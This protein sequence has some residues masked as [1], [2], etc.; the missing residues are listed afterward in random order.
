MVSDR[1]G[2]LN[3]IVAISLAWFIVSFTWL[4]VH[5][6]LGYYAFTVVYGIISASFQCLFP[7]TIA[8]ITPRLDTI[9]TRLG[10]AF[11]VGAIASLTGPSIGGA[12]QM[13]GGGSFRRPQIWAATVTLVAFLFFAAVRLH[14][15]GL[16]LK[17]RV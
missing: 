9:G 3:V 12:I 14:M 15:G 11:S 1:I 8:R 17:A 16:S 6:V 5:D 10:M 2:N 7:S 13:S 4:A